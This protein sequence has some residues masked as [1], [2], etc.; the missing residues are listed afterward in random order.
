MGPA[1]GF[2]VPAPL[3]LLMRPGHPEAPVRTTRGSEPTFLAPRRCVLHM[4]PSLEHPLV[5]ST[6]LLKERPVLNVCFRGVAEKR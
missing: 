3:A 2:P 6:V 5:A 1:R 4:G